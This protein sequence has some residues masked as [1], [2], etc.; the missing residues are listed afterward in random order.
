MVYR[1]RT[2]V[3]GDW[4]ND[5]TAI[6]KLYSW[7]SNKNLG[8][9]FTDAH[10]LKQARDSSLNCSIKSSLKERLDAS[11][12]FVLIVGRSTN[13]ITAGSCQYCSSYDSYHHYC[14]RGYFVDYRSYIK[15]ECDEAFKAYKEGKMKIIVLYNMRT[16]D[17]SKCPE[18]LRNIGIHS[19]M[20]KVYE[21]GEC[22]YDYQTVKRAFEMS[23]LS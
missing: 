21:D 9:N 4:D 12:R 7:N 6:D 19:S 20:G 15:Y 14:H 3:A 16:V 5:K 18:I 8:L 17:R 1:T 22:Y 13:D 2:Y 23:D 11:N 10:D